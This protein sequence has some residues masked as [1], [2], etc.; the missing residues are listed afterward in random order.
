VKYIID[1]NAFIGWWHHWYPPSCHGFWDGLDELANTNQLLV[2]EEVLAELRRRGDD[3][4]QWVSQRRDRLVV[5]HS[6]EIDRAVAG[7]V[8]K[9][10][11]KLRQRG[12]S[13]NADIYIVAYA[14]LVR[15]CVITDERQARRR[16]DN[17][18]IEGRYRIPDLC[19]K[20][21]IT[22]MRSF[23]L[24]HKVEWAFDWNG[25]AHF[26]ADESS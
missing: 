7:L 18:E 14:S 22:W 21:S 26:R 1:S 13:D 19:A 5:P 9:Y 15:G 23:Q 24:I 6:G 8:A 16:R 25:T 3:L 4:Y 17:G 10:P 2:L 12:H 20:E 11:N